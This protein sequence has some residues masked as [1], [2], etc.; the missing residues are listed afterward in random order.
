MEHDLTKLP[1]WAQ[2]L[3]EEKE[4]ENNLLKMANKGLEAAH[5]ILFN[6]E[7]FV[8]NGPIENDNLAITNLWYLSNEHPHQVCSIGVG[9]VFVIGRDKKRISVFD[10]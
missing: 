7:W 1:K 9:D 3:I 8:I 6:R 5:S 4:A 2:L 10:R